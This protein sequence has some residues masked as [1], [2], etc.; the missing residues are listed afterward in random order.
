MVIPALNEAEN[1]PHVFEHAPRRIHEVILVDGDSTDG[2]VDVARELL[3]RHP[4]RQPERHGQGR[5]PGAG[6]PPAPAT[7][8]SCSTPTG[9]PTRR[10]IPRFVDAL[11]A[12]A[13]FAKGSRFASGG[14]S[15]DIT[16]LRRL[17]NRA[18]SASVNVLFGTRFT[19]LCYGYN[20]FWRR[21]LTRISTS[22]PAGF[23]VETADE[24]P[25]GRG[26]L[27]VSRGRRATS[28]RASTARATCGPSA[29][30]GACCAR[31]VANRRCWVGTGRQGLRTRS[32]PPAV[33]KSPRTRRAERTA[34]RGPRGAVHRGSAQRRPGGRIGLPRIR[35]K[36]FVT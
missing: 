9:P 13:D 30:A 28:P 20:A 27:Q 5:R 15:D 7:S 18:L 12:G 32:S 22:T 25:S 2:T 26:R 11:V 33:T 4:R 34:P 14:G 36:R 1:L 3:A 8:S 35:R 31:S 19:D 21:C 23:E 17:G 10:E 24:H 6:S 29:T 16:P